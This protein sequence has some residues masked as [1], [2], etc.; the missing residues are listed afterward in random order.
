MFAY[1]DAPVIPLMVKHLPHKYMHKS[2]SD[3]FEYMADYKKNTRSEFEE[4]FSKTLKESIELAKTSDYGM[5]V[6]IYSKERSPVRISEGYETEIFEF[7]QE[8]KAKIEGRQMTF[9]YFG[10]DLFVEFWLKNAANLSS[11]KDFYE[12]HKYPKLVSL[13]KSFKNDK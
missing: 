13:L 7:V 10:V 12:N 1:L 9:P 5:E 4:G 11:H 2:I 6:S 8:K 3:L